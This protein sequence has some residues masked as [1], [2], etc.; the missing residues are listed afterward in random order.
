MAQP[1]LDYIAPEIQMDTAKIRSCLVDM[2]SM[3]ML[4]CAL[5]NHGK[6]LLQ[7]GHNTATYAK[8]MEQVA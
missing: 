2:F 3:G 5:Y 4:I 7:S 6:S 8:R 1:D